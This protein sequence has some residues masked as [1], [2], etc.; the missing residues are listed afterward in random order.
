MQFL[1]DEMILKLRLLSSGGR[2]ESWWQPKNA[3]F[4]QPEP[5]TVMIS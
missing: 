1:R 4:V 5:E 2:V 3:T